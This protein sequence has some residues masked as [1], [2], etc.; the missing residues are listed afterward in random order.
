MTNSDKKSVGVGVIPEAIRR[1]QEALDSGDAK[2]CTYALNELKNHIALIVKGL[3]GANEAQTQ[4]EI[5]AGKKYL[6]HLEQQ[7]Q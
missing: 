2:Q 7:G 6:A 5:E 3:G 1:H 4:A